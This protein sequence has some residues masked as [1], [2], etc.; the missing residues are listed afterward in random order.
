V[1]PE[2]LVGD[3]DTILSETLTW[4]RERGVD[5]LAFDPEKDDT[6]LSLAFR[7]VRERG[8]AGRGEV[9]VTC[10]IGGRPDH[11]LGVFGVL[12]KN[13][14]LA[15]WLFEDGIEGRVLSPM[16]IPTWEF[17]DQRVGATFSAVALASKN[18]ISERGMRWEVDHLPMEP[19]QDRAL[20][21]VIERAGA[22]I[23]CD[24]GI[25]AAFLF[26]EKR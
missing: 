4:A 20:S 11:F 10:A 6:D 7:A 5:E 18:A 19:L 23:T 13:A 16:G 12:A 3:D 9:A 25:V 21:N 8:L 26:A 1:V 22:S 24:T 14:D 15:P 17:S 2:L